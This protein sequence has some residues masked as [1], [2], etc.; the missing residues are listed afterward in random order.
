MDQVTIETRAKINRG[1]KIL[2]QRKDGYHLLKSKMIPIDL[3][4]QIIL[5]KKDKGLVYE[6]NLVDLAWDKNNFCY[7]CLDLLEKN[8]NRKFHL[9]IHLKKKIPLGAGLAGGTANGAGILKGIN[10]LY[11]LG[12]DLQ[13]LQ[14]WALDL[15]ADFPFCLYDHPAKVGGIGEK[16]EPIEEKVIPLLLINPGYQLSTK[17]V[18]AWYDQDQDKSQ[19]SGQLNDLQGPVLRR[20]PDLLQVEKALKESGAFEVSMSGSGPT[21]YGLYPSLELRDQA[22]KSLEG[23]FP[24][25]IAGTTGI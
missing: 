6:S 20:H 12:L 16:I 24:L 1:L 3:K 25:L 5:K 15:G 7:K 21:F 14:A 2:G 18:Y 10:Q 4:D 19:D 11:D 22:K 13:T 17:E 9:E 8:L 23:S